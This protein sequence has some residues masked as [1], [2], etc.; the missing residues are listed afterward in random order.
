MTRFNP[1]PLHFSTKFTN[2]NT[3]EKLDLFYNRY[4]TNN[5]YNNIYIYIYIY[6]YI[7]KTDTKKI[8]QRKLRHC[9]VALAQPRFHV[10]DALE[11]AVSRNFP[12]K[13]NVNPKISIS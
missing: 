1:F 2:Q 11:I 10:S 5:I 7:L 13:I 3:E 4:N 6:I 12:R 8:K 9:K